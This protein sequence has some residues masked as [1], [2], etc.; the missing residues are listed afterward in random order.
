MIPLK[1][2]RGY[3]LVRA[4]AGEEA[5]RATLYLY[6]VIGLDYWDGSGIS[7]QRLAADL[8]QLGPVAL[9]VR[10]NS[11]GGDVAEGVAIYNLLARHSAE[12]IVHVDAIAASI[13][14]VIAMA[15]TEI[16]MSEAG[17][18]MVHQPWT[19]ASGDAPEMR[20]TADVLD[21]YW[22]AIL[23]TYARRT[24]RRAE[25]IAKKVDD[26]SGEWWMTAEEAVAQGFADVVS[27]PEKDTQ[28]RAWGT[29]R[30]AKAPARIAASAEPTKHPPQRPA[31]TLVELAAPRLLRAD[32][33]DVVAQRR[34]AVDVLRLS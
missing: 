16:R 3:G 21:K 15:G 23:A 27:T 31:P 9:D 26:A 12:V 17:L 7:A 5:K 33:A 19:W 14:T 29:Q 1:D 32:S 10:I 34:R 22:S 20:R 30:F 18:L 25:T 24:G 6:D 11:P 28:A 13:A 4:E 8:E 2:G